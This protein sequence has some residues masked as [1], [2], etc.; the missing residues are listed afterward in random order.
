MKSKLFLSLAVL[1]LAFSV[2]ACGT[3]KPTDA[4]ATA[5]PPTAVAPTQAPAPTEAPKPTDAPVSGGGDVEV[6]QV[7]YYADEFS[8]YHVVGLI[9]NNGSSALNN[10][11]LIIEAKDAAG[12]TLLTD[13]DN[14]PVDTT[15]FYPLTSN[16]FPGE[17]T[18]FDYSL[19]NESG[20]APDKVI[21][22]FSKADNSRE[23]RGNVVV[24]NAQLFNDGGSFYLTGELVNKSDKP[25]YVED[26]AGAIFSSQGEI[27][28]ADWTTTVAYYLTPAGDSSGM[29]RTPFVISINGPED[30]PH[31]KWEL[32]VDAIESKSYEVPELYVAFTNNYFDDMGS[33]HIV[34]TLENRD[35]NRTFS[36]YLLAGL[37][38]ANGV[39]VDAVSTSLPMYITPGQLMVFDTTYFSVVDWYQSQADLV[40]TF[41]VQLDPYWTYESP[42]DVVAL[43]ATNVNQTLEGATATFTG[44][45]TNSSGKE[46][47]WI[48]VQVNLY[49]GD[50]IIASNYTTIFPDGDSFAAGSTGSFDL[51]IYLDPNQDT[52]NVEYEVIVQGAV[53]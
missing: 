45:V 37:Y 16:L 46:L 19:Y 15:T 7:I 6:S 28:G 24:E 20:A 3:P 50:V 8:T 5:V 9:K 41:T 2:L 44:D 40:D 39:V 11:E 34:G 30:I 1:L 22:S 10:I 14:N 31:D 38:D 12:N 43:E 51:N 49:E 18:A 13:F 48:S 53:K 26:L 25:A 52:T 33:F 4:P 21:V 29:D 32:Y 27:M 42:Y 17:M 36:T 35:P 23:K 47:S